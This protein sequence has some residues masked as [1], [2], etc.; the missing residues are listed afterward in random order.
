MT[1][2]VKK[3]EK[4][5]KELHEE[6]KKKQPPDVRKIPIWRLKNGKHISISEMNN[7]TLMT[8]FH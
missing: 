2:E 4:T 3:E 7:R 6:E 8:V 5:I 1:E